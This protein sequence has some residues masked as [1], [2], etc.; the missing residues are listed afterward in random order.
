MYFRH[1][2]VRLKL[3][4]SLQYF[5]IEKIG[6]NN[7]IRKTAKHPTTDL[8]AMVYGSFTTTFLQYKEEIIRVIELQKEI[9]R[10]AII[11]VEEKKR[12]FESLKETFYSWNCVSIINYK[13][14]YDFEIEDVDQLWTFINGM[15]HLIAIMRTSPENQKRYKPLFKVQNLSLYKILRIKMKISYDAFI[16]N[17]SLVEHYLTAIIKSAGHIETLKDIEIE[18]KL[19]LTKQ[20]SAVNVDFTA[21]ENQF[22]LD[23]EDKIKQLDDL[24]LSNKGS[25][26]PKDDLEMS[27][28][29]V[30]FEPNTPK[31][32]VQLKGARALISLNK[33]ADQ[34]G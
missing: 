15:Q 31:Y 20:P 22:K 12:L 32:I 18:K 10:S 13:R 25:E 3:A 4:E 6:E 21:L 14:T 9:R 16:K 27:V 1:Y 26:S 17:R 8:I 2:E 5:T 7:L 24:L 33:N 23:N 34:T 28:D 30:L 19:S 29:N 11:K